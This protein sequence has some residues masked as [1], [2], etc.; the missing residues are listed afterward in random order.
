MRQSQNSPSSSPRKNFFFWTGTGV[1]PAPD[2]IAAIAVDRPFATI[3]GCRP[4]KT[5]G[6][7]KIV[8]LHAADA[9]TA[10]RLQRR[11][12]N[13]NFGLHVSLTC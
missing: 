8:L 9:E 10:V 7:L 2:P 11:C 5:H 13:V 6:R 3:P 4:A 12:C 1:E